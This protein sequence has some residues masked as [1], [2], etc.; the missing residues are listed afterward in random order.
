MSIIRVVIIGL[1][2]FAIGLIKLILFRHHL[3]NIHDTL[4]VFFFF[5]KMTCTTHAQ[6]TY[7]FLVY[8][9]SAYMIPF[10]K[11]NKLTMRALGAQSVT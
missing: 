5:G 3:N 2:L 10:N 9:S 8:D 1:T 11:N 4:K 6:H 7:N